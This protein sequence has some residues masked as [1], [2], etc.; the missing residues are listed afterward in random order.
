MRSG[1][2]RLMPSKFTTL[3]HCYDRFDHLQAGGGGYGCPLERD[4]EAV[5]RDVRDGK[6][7]LNSA[8][9]AYGVV[10]DATLGTVDIAATMAERASRSS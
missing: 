9:S 7:S 3:I 1:N 6:V 2:E 10:I 4:P 8:R 5:L